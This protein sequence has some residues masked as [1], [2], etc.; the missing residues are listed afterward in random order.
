MENKPKIAILRW[1]QG[2]VPEGLMQLES[3]PGNSTNTD[4]YPFEVK[5]VEVKGACVETVITHP[6]E[7]LLEDMIALSMELQEDGIEAIT[8]SCGFNAIFQKRMADALKIPVFT[9]S[10]L[11]VP[12]VQNIIGRNRSVGIVTANKSSLTKQHFEACGIDDSVKTVVMG[13][14]NAKEWSKIFDEPD[15]KFDIDAVGA[16]ILGVAKEGQRQNPDMGA[17]VLECTDLPPYARRI[18]EATGLPVFDFNSM[19][20]YIAISLGVLKIY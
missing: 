14:E 7:K 11:Q 17:I 8:T 10:L 13:L 2:K 6:S 3:M 9:S 20:S 5:L 18:S 16:E 15:K 1:E 19:I 12:F 4:S